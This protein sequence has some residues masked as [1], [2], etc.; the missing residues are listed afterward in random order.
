MLQHS[1]SWPLTMRWRAPRVRKGW[2]QSGGI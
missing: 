1:D 2:E